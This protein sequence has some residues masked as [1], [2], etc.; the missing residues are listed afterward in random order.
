MPHLRLIRP[1]RNTHKRYRQAK[2]PMKILISP[3]GFK[4]SLG[5]A[6]VATCIETGI[7]RVLPNA[8]IRKVPLV[9]GGEGT[10]RTLTDHTEGEL[11]QLEVTGPVGQKVKSHYGFL[12]GQA[13]K[14]AI[15]EMAA[16]A[17]LH[18]V[19]KTARDPTKT[20]TYGVGELIA[21]A[22]NRGAER[23]LIGCGDSGTS[24]GGAGLLQALGARL[25]D[26]QGCELPKPANGTTLTKL[27]SMD[28]TTVHPRLHKIVLEV[29]C[30][31]HN[32]L[33]GP[34]GVARVYGP[35]KGASPEQVELLD[36]ALDNF[37]SVAHSKLGYEVGLLPGSGASGGMGAGLTLLGAHMRPRYEA[38]ME[39]F[40][41][42]DLFEDCQLVFTAEGGIDFQTPN[43]KIPSDVANRA[44][45]FGIPVIA[46]AGT[47]G[48][49]AD[50]NYQAGIDAF[51]S[52]LQAPTT[53]DKAILEAERLVTDAAEST[54][55]M[56]MVGLSL[57]MGYESI[58]TPKTPTSTLSFRD[59]PISPVTQIS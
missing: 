41:I 48:Q 25:L 9:D 4:E 56:V 19:P 38:I 27:A 10:A 3:S 17:G 1:G 24:D 28:L 57:G 21:D 8:A 37:A 12:G 47:V 58:A 42:N 55:R 39:W 34:K 29:A 35:Q 30:N 20:T 36:R 40:G 22:L 16:A 43:G 46:L 59:F 50:A 11:I 51:T 44:K 13:H 15:V 52:I 45:A 33:L 14:T 32:I 2:P 23:V 18:M 26:D 54:M 7:R 31:W 5:P 49:G 53:L 6:E